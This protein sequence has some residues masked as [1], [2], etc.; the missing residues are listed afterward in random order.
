MKPFAPYYPAKPYRVN[1]AWGILNPIYERFGWSRH[2]GT[3]IALGTDKRLYAP[4][5]GTIVRTGNQP[6]GGGVFLGLMSKDEF[7]FK[8]GRTARVLLDMLHCEEL[9][10]VE[11]QETKTGE[12]LAIGDNTG[13]STGDH[14]HLQPRRVKKWNGKSG[15]NLAWTALDKN[16]ANGS[17]DIGLYWN[18]KYASDLIPRFTFT[19]DLEY[20]SRGTEVRELQKYLNRSGFTVAA[21]GEG[22]LG[23]ETTYFGKATQTALGAFQKAKGIVP[24]AG[25]FG[26]ITRSYINNH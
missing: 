1:Q 8:D 23:K 2:N 22:S 18:G 4:F 16:D 9:L 5:D 7:L 10:C 14:T 24:A 17:F 13:F 21:S 20:G 11:G 25:Y 6:T 26:P 15:N 12:L 3:D 19:R